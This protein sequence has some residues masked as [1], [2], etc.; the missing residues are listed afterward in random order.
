MKRVLVVFLIISLLST[1]YVGA[2]TELGGTEQTATEQTATEQHGTEDSFH[3][4]KV[5]SVVYDDS[6]ST[7]TKGYCWSYLNYAMQTI[8]AMTNEQDELYITYMSKAK[9]DGAEAARLDLSD[10]AAVITQIR[11]YFDMGNTPYESVDIAM[12]A[13]RASEDT[14]P[15]TQYWLIVLTDGEFQ[16]D[17]GN[18]PHVERRELQ[19]EMEALT[20]ETMANGSHPHVIYMGFG[21]E[22]VT[23]RSKP[24]KGLTGFKIKDPET[25]M[26]ILAEISNDI[27]GQAEVED[28]TVTDGA[29]T[30]RAELP[31]Y[32]VSLLAQ[33]GESTA[34][35]A[36]GVDAT[37]DGTAE[38]S[39]DDSA[40]LQ[41]PY[42]RGFRTDKNLLGSFA[43][44]S[45]G[46]E[47]FPAGEY[48][49]ETEGTI[50]EDVTVVM[51]EPA[52]RLQVEDREETSVFTILANDVPLTAEQAAKNGLTIYS[53][54]VSPDA[55]T[56]RAG[57]LDSLSFIKMPYK[58]EL[59]E[60]GTYTL[61]QNGVSIFR[62]LYKPGQ[63]VTTVALANDISITADSVLKVTSSG[64]NWLHFVWQLAV[65]AGA[66][67]GIVR[68]IK[69]RKQP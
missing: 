63:Y 32:S 52:V 29:V 39:L 11:D 10:K 17:H 35:S 55:D 25:I 34:L 59:A 19:R 61:K 13:L 18:G 20:A 28:V 21:R 38:L 37:G 3:D 5:I 42:R 26:S 54:Q 41:Y 36:A 8:A 49:I 45:A 56:A 43:T 16:R 30:F 40:I 14:D 47:I 33:G 22:A 51:I 68:L 4:R 64:W 50:S 27:S 23:V 69:A 66:V 1:V 67:W 12:N 60:D 24:S 31:F 58:L 48:R 44:L 7:L 6:D 15:G 65:I 57:F 9:V 62:Y 53:S 46:G 2:Q